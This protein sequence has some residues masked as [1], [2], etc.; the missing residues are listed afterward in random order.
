MLQPPFFSDRFPP[1]RN[2]GGVGTVMGHEFTHG[3]DDTG[4]KCAA[5]V[6]TSV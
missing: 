3:F 4:R 5:A 1:E 6:L 2:F